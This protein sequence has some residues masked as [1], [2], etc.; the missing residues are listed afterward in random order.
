MQHSRTDEPVIIRVVEHHGIWAIPKEPS[1]QLGWNAAGDPEVGGRHLLID[2]GEWA[3]K[4][5][6][7]IHHVTV[8][9][10]LALTLRTSV[11]PS[12][13]RDLASR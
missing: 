12:C 8:L 5:T 2:R 10:E 9:S 1:V 6:I 13:R 11:G 7:D 4:E 3:F